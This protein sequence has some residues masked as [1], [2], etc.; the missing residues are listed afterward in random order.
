ML[1]DSGCPTAPRQLK[2][3]QIL[4][5]ISFL[6]DRIRDLES[7]IDEL[8]GNITPKGEGGKQAS[9]LP[10]PNAVMIYNAMPETIRTAA[11]RIGKL[12][13]VL[14]EFFI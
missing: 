10:Q 8:N 11:E 14:R 1:Q 6:S 7:L 2:P 5:S 3:Q 12:T 9:T 4:E 13:S